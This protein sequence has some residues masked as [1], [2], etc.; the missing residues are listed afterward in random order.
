M[1]FETQTL[2]RAYQELIKG[3]PFRVAV[4]NFMNSFFLYDT[5]E[6][7]S[8]LDEPVLLSEQPNE[9][10]RHWAAFCAGAAEYLA[11]RYDLAI[12]LW[13]KDNAYAL[14]ESWCVVPEAGEDLVAHFEQSTPEPFLR[15]K[16]LCGDTIFTNAHRSSKEP[17]TFQ[18]RRRRLREA[19]AEMQAE[20]RAAY[21]ARYNARV[22]SWIQL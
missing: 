1:R 6:R 14:A 8:L 7:Q 5:E 4:G 12:P 2:A 15:R 9:D 17:G 10:E 18:D 22:P 11:A 3:E 13:A 20:D 21:I 16:V 19:L